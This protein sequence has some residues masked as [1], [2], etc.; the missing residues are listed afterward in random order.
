MSDASDILC[1]QVLGP[2]LGGGWCHGGHHGTL[3]PPGP[4]GAGLPAPRKHHGPGASY[5]PLVGA[6]VFLGFVEYIYYIL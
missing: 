5:L 4:G 6:A 3:P 2:L 1:A